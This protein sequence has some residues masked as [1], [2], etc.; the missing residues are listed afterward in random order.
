MSGVEM[1]PTH[2][3]TDKANNFFNDLGEVD[4]NKD[5]YL[6]HEEIMKHLKLF[7]GSQAMQHGKIFLRN[8][9][10]L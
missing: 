1:S 5:G 2:T 10:E 6:T 3:L 9:D 7:V 8:R 4:D